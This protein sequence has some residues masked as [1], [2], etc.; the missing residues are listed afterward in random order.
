FLPR[1]TDPTGSAQC[2]LKLAMHVDEVLCAGCL[3][4][5]VDVLGDG[6][7]VTVL[8]L[9]PGKSEM[10]CVGPRL[11][12][13]GATEIVEAMHENWV[14][15]EGFGRR[16]VLDPEI[17]PESARPAKGAKPALGGQPRPG[18]DYDAVKFGHSVLPHRL[19]VTAKAGVQFFEWRFS[20]WIP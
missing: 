6:Q 10:G 20:R 8:A 2:P 14:A 15:R 17:L 16:H 13:P 1:R 12:M 19:A 9:E 3:V 11:F 7:H 5:R 18:Q 4:Q